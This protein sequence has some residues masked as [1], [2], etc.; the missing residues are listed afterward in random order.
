MTETI[1]LALKT[2]EAQL[3]QPLET[4]ME[5]CA[6]CGLCAEAC[7]Y[8]RAEPKL[9]H[10]PAQRAEQLRSVY[11]YEHDFL[12]RVFPA[13][14]GATK[15]DEITLANLT[16]IAP[17]FAVGFVVGKMQQRLCGSRVE[18]VC[19]NLPV[20]SQQGVHVLEKLVQPT[21]ICGHA[22]PV[23]Y[24]ENGV[25]AA[26]VKPKDVSLTSIG[27]TCFAHELDCFRRHIDS[28]NAIAS[29]LE[30]QAVVS[31]PSP[32]IENIAPASIKRRLLQAGEL[33]R[34]SKEVANRDFFSEAIIAT[35]GDVT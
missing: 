11:R 7:H 16:E 28:A 21:D 22:Y 30:S 23:T 2:L 34:P 5:A 32:S 19:E 9:E 15:L 10:I 3:N 25:K 33:L 26:T 35:D 24:H 29:G 18:R 31:C 8:Y 12:S 17:G 14:T 27:H 4:A 20:W 6:R 1:E 13:W